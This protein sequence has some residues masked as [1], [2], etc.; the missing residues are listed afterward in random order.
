MSSC[1]CTLMCIVSTLF[2]SIN[3]KDLF[4]SGFGVF[5]FIMFRCSIGYIGMLCNMIYLFILSLHSNHT[6]CH[7]PILVIQNGLQDALLGLG[8]EIWERER[9][10]WNREKPACPH[11]PP[12]NRNNTMNHNYTKKNPLEPQIQ[13]KIA[14]ASEEVGSDQSARD[15]INDRRGWSNRELDR[16]RYPAI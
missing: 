16:E 8:M 13:K 9:E 5:V 4:F 12:S 10:S 15:G 1:L 11:S 14:S 6:R 3:E 7:R 2:P